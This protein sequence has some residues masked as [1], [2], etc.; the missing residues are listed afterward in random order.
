M[1]VIE[2]KLPGLILIEPKVFHD[3]R[4]FFYESFQATKY[5]ELGITK[6]F[7]QDNVSCSCR[8]VLRGLHYQLQRPQGKLVTVIRGAV[9]DVVVDI[10]QGSPTFGQWQSF[11]LNDENHWQL[12]VPEGFAHGFV[13]LSEQVDFHYKCTDYYQPGDEYGIIWNDPNLA[14]PWNITNPIMSDKDLIFPCLADVP[15]GY[16]PQY[17][18]ES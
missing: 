8:N 5:N 9:L 3:N 7:V 6:P 18:G 17:Q 11:E 1:R 13:A 15:L 4:G 10:R 2:T 12:Y 14:I 16:L